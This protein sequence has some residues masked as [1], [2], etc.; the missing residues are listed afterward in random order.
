MLRTHTCGELRKSDAGK[1]VMLCGWLHKQREHP[2]VNFV[3]LKDRYGV[4]QI[5]A[6][7]DAK[8]IVHPLRRDSVIKVTGTVVVKPE[9]NKNLLTGEIE[10]QATSIE[11]L[12]E[13]EALPVDVDDPNIT[14]ESRLT[15]RYI[16][17]RRP[18]MQNNLLVRHKAALAVRQFLDS[19][20]FVEV[21]TPML[22]RH[23]PEGARD[24]VVPSRLHKDKWYSLPQSPQIYKQILMVAGTD[25]YFQLA[26][27]MRDE[28][29]RADRQPEF[30]QIDLEMSFVTEDDIFTLHER[31]MANLFKS[32]L[33]IDLK[34]PFDRLTYHESMTRFGSDKPDLR[35][36]LELVD[37]TTVMKKLPVNAFEE[38]EVVYC[39]NAKGCAS[40]SR[41][42]IDKLNNLAK[43]Y[44]TKGIFWMRWGARDGPLAKHVSEDVAPDIEKAVGA[45]EEDLLI[46]IADSWVRATT[47]LGHIR[48]EV[49]RITDA[50]PKDTFKFAWIHEFP[51]FEWDEEGKYWSAMHH[52]FTM[53][54]QEHIELLESDPGKVLG[55]LYDLTLNGVEMGSGSIRI[56]RKDIQ[57]RV[58]KVVG[59]DFEQ[60]AEK[61]GFMLKAFQYGAPPHGGFAIGFDRLVALMCKQG[62]IREVIA[63][64]KNKKAEGMMESSPSDIDDTQRK[65]LGL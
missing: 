31:M 27:C 20:Q 60:A 26:R 61:F 54:K 1:E 53:P 4:T 59:F 41:K 65:E 10:I 28:D 5:A 12:N 49:A 57:E 6:S 15:Y 32:V 48:N 35:F 9:P 22:C 39:F 7:G 47:A 43:T 13:A 21:E 3:E 38:N 16:D 11:I 42:K 33:D 45:E 18:V 56:H 50:I 62:D 52:I 63:F 19:E 8:A 55:Y 2:N 37:A 29:L 44:H 51:L 36:G 17:L 34:I 40:W 30:T 58:L 25:R 46:F 64:P 24:Y 14:E 23:T